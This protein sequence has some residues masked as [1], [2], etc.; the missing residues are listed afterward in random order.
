MGSSTAT[1]LLGRTH[2]SRREELL[3]YLEDPEM[4]EVHNS[5]SF[6]ETE[7]TMGDNSTVNKMGM[8]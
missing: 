7:C 5:D 8:S 1:N 2:R 6:S 4:V 3:D